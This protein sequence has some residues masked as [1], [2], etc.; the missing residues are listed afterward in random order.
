[1]RA[2]MLRGHS[3]VSEHTAGTDSRRG[4]FMNKRRMRLTGREAICEPKRPGLGKEECH[5]SLPKFE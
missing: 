4:A 3:Y 2:R 1:M 5:A